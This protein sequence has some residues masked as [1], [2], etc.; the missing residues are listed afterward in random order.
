MAHGIR[1]NY[2]ILTNHDPLWY[3]IKQHWYLPKHHKNFK[4]I[5]QCIGCG[6]PTRK[7]FC[8]NRCREI[9]IKEREVINQYVQ[10]SV[11]NS[12]R[13]RESNSV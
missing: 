13:N 6:K 1:R 11:Y 8:S 12:N 4:S 9:V 3:V 7:E 5:G 10:N 2:N